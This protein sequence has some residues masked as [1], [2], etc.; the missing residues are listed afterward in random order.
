VWILVTCT[1]QITV[2][3]VMT[4]EKNL[5]IIPAQQAFRK[6]KSASV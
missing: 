3:S 6:I 2:F 1:A 5:R 4:T